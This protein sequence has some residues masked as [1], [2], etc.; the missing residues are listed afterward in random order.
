MKAVRECFVGL[1][2]RAVRSI[3]VL[4]LLF[5]FFLIFLTMEAIERCR[6]Y[7]PCHHELFHYET[8]TIGSEEAEINRQQQ[9]PGLNRSDTFYVGRPR[10]LFSY[11]NDSTT[12]FTKANTYRRRYCQSCRDAKAYYREVNLLPNLSIEERALADAAAL[13]ALEAMEKRL[14]LAPQ[15]PEQVSDETT[16]NQEAKTGDL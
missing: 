10:E 8:F 7:C 4:P 2:L 9:T 15:R 3:L 16:E 5:L 1:L 14:G 11:A 12:E 6:R 13:R